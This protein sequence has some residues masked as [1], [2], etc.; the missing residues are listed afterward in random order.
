M[1]GVIMILRG[2]GTFASLLMLLIFAGALFS[3]PL[4]ILALRFL[5]KAVQELKAKPPQNFWRLLASKVLRSPEPVKQWSLMN[6]RGWSSKREK[7]RLQPH[8]SST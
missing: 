6:G 2:G 8:V 7:E 4:V 3:I 5:E 1:I